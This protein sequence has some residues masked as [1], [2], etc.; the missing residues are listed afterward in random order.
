[1]RGDLGRSW[2]SDRPILP[3]L[4]ARL[5]WSLAI[6]LGGLALGL[7]AGFALGLAAAGGSRIGAAAS[8]AV[9]TAAQT[10]P[11]FGVGLLL[12]WAFAV[13]L[14]W[15]RPFTGGLAE[16]LCL[17]V[18]T[19]AFFVAGPAARIAAASFEDA[20]AAPW[21]VAARAKGLSEQA[22][23]LRH[24]APHAALALLAGASPELAWVVG[25]A[26]VTE[27]VFATPGLGVWVVEAV[28]ARDHAVLQV[29][30]ALVLGWMAAAHGLVRLARR[31]LDPRPAALR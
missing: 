17:P 12:V 2:A 6:G 11:A 4:A 25:G 31:R 10:L 16:M 23:I 19:V 8:R 26:A 14:G 7:A 20:R 13:E 15:L 5:P 27:V 24:A 9:A 21:F 3:E 29:Y 18:L 1:M 28:A 22:V 30:L